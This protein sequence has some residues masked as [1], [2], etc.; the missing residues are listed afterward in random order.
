MIGKFS[1][2]LC[3]SE[4]CQSPPE[5]PSAADYIWDHEAVPAISPPPTIGGG[6]GGM[7]VSVVRGADTKDIEFPGG[8]K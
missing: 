8:A 3:N 5:G 6:G 2:S 7:K 4:Q 1:L